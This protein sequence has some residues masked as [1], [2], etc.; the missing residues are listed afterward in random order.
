MQPMIDSPDEVDG[1]LRV[2]GHA[3][4]RSLAPLTVLGV[5]SLLLSAGALWTLGGSVAWSILPI[6]LLVSPLVLWALDKIHAELFELPDRPGYRVRQWRTSFLIGIPAFLSTWVM[7]VAPIAERSVWLAFGLIAAVTMLAVVVLITSVALPVAVIR[8]D[9]GLAAIVMCAF[10][11]LVRRPAAAIAAVIVPAVAAWLG[12]TWF[13]GLLIAVLPCF[14]VLSVAAAWTT[15]IAFGVSAP[16]I[17]HRGGKR[18]RTI[19]GLT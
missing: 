16:R 12:L 15:V 7:A 9:V 19:G 18:S 1:V 10:L 4:W 2:L 14:V 17:M 6:G 8:G 5:G 13:A 11:A 3:T